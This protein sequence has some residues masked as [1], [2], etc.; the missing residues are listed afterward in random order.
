MDKQEY[1]AQRKQSKHPASLFQTTG[2]MKT[3]KLV[4]EKMKN[5]NAAIVLLIDEP[6]G[7]LDFFHVFS[8]RITIELRCVTHL[9]VLFAIQLSSYS[10]EHI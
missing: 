6:Q 7:K 10:I 1:E 2:L 4:R 9:Y 3:S 8:Y 5:E